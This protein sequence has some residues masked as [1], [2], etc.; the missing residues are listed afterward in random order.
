VDISFETTD[1]QQ[2]C[3]DDRIAKRRFGAEAAKK[4]RRRLDDLAAASIL[5]MMKV[6]PGRCHELKG[7][8]AGHL[9]MDLDGGR[10][11]VFRPA[12]DPIPTKDD[13][14]LDWSRVTAICVTAIADYH[15]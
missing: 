10:R 5:S 13:G 4:L 2:T 15:D 1:L 14:G 11:L 9:A 7:D 6:L 8:L 12:D 3:N